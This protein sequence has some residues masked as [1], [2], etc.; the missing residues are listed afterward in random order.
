[1]KAETPDSVVFDLARQTVRELN[2]FLHGDL[3]GVKRVL[4]DNPDGAP[5]RTPPNRASLPSFQMLH[6]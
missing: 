3:A 2:Q 1:M 6:E 5:G 4:V